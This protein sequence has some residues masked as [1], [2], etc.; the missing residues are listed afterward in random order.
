MVLNGF[1]AEADIERERVTI[2][3]EFRVKVQYSRS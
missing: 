1:G 2:V 3:D